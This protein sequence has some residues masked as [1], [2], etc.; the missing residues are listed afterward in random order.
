VDAYTV[1]TY[2]VALY[3]FDEGH[4]PHDATRWTPCVAPSVA[5]R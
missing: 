1:D 5:S 2:T 3:H 4:A